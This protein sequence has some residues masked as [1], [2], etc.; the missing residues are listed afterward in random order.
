VNPAPSPHP[1][2]TADESTA[3]HAFGWFA[4]QAFAAMNWLPVRVTAALFAI[5]GNFEDAVNCWRTQA[6]DWPDKNNG[7]LLSS[8]AGAIGVQL[9]LPVHDLPPEL[10]PDNERPGLGMSEEADADFMQSTVG[11]VWRSLVLSLLV[12]ALVQISAWVG[13]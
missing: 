5:V 4:H 8:G 3:L 1:L 13:G 10:E 2:S 7:I 11:L 9:G 12:L 6:S